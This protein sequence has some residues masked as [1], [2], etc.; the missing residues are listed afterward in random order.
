MAEL[1]ASHDTLKPPEN[2][3]NFLQSGGRVLPSM[4][5]GVLK[6][7]LA[8]ARTGSIRL[9]SEELFVAPSAVSRQMTAL[10]DDLGIPLF[11]RSAKGVRLTSA[12]EV[13]ASTARSIVRKMERVRTEIDDLR[14]LKRGHVTI[15]A[16]E[17]VVAE[18]LFPLLATFNK[19]FPN[20]SFEIQVTGTEGVLRALIED[21]GD[22]G[23][24]FNPELSNEVLAIKETLHPV[25]AVALP[26][27]PIAQHASMR[28]SV[29]ADHVLGLPD[30]TFG[31]RRL[32]DE[33]MLRE[34]IENRP[35]LQVNSIEMA[36]AFVRAGM[37]LTVL[38]EFALRVEKARGEFAIVQL[39]DKVGALS[40]TLALC[41]H[42]DRHL[43]AAARRVL[44][45]LNDA[46]LSS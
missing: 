31:V 30:R 14:G 18:F 15:Y 16:V 45:V 35:F 43:S 32:L 22:I 28:V 13:F 27:H 2:V 19:K 34:H 25:V 23:L 39:H 37:G 7:F 20:I 5:F 36:K 46:L 12:G 10:E 38:P 4:Q 29:L 21:R 8:V 3:P 17:G 6:Y 44:S 24:A 40:A 11:E 1:K 42:R 9:A 33:S 41:T 26:D